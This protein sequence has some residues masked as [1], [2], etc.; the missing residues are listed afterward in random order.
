MIPTRPHHFHGGWG[1]GWG[2]G[3]RATFGVDCDA[4]PFDKEEEAW[5]HRMA[6][7]DAPNDEFAIGNF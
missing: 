2:G 7:K 6:L 4:R 5:E 3:P 1:W